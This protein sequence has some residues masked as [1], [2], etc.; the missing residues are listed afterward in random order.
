MCNR[1]ESFSQRK[2]LKPVK[3]VMQ[4]DSMDEDL[5]NG[6]WNVLIASYWDRVKPQLDMEGYYRWDLSSNREMEK[7][8]WSLQ[9]NYF[10]KPVDEM[11]DKWLTI[12]NQLRDYFFRCPWNEV[13][14]FIEFVANNYPD[15]YANQRFMTLCNSVLEREVSA[16]RFVGGR[17]TQ[18][19]SEREIA[20]IEEAL[21]KAPNA[22]YI[23]LK[24]AFDLLTDRR[25]PDYRNSI[26]ESI[27]AV[28][29]VCKQISGN[30]KAKLEQ[31]LKAIQEKTRLHPALKKAFSNL[32][33]YTSDAQGIRHALID[34]SNLDFEDAKFM[35][36]SCSA[37][38]NYLMAK[39]SKLNIKYQT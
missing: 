17:I 7:L 30:P 38:I 26:K 12:R 23:H 14:D 24:T 19:T 25:S 18:I 10:K 3:S 21:E 28:E 34:E 2:G 1:M 32:Y 15:K 8:V 9:I 39:G 33:G 6:L 31:A 5:R 20:E 27:S 36:V 4:V 37:F 13:Y 16:Y 22:V 35:L 29:A 11:G